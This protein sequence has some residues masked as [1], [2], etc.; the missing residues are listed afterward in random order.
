META[1]RWK[2]PQSPLPFAPLLWKARGSQKGSPPRQPRPPAQPWAKDGEFSLDLPLNRTKP[3]KLTRKRHV[4]A[5]SRCRRLPPG[6]P[7]PGTR[8]RHGGCHRQEWGTCCR[9]PP[10]RQGAPCRGG[11]HGRRLGLGH[12]RVPTRS[13]G[14]ILLEPPLTAGFK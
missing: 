11:P 1:A 3:A 5:Y 8:R 14:N 13:L 6:R 9:T 7:L 12:H 4:N 10:S 2:E